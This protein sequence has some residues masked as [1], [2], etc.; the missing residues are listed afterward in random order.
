[1]GFLPLVVVAAA[2]AAGVAAAA[3]NAAGS[4]NKKTKISK[5]MWRGRKAVGVGG[6]Q[7]TKT[8]IQH[9][10]AISVS[11]LKSYKDTAALHKTP[12][13]EPYTSY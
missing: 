13:L 3:L 8:E 7:R 5:R 6:D 4:I 9:T 2:A 12:P 1:M 10:V 11:H